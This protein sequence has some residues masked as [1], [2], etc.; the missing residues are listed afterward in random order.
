[1]FQAIFVVLRRA[2]IVLRTKDSSLLKIFPPRVS[3]LT[4]P[5]YIKN[6]ETAHN[7]KGND[8]E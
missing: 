1:M 6:E 8:N 3:F 5:F 7:R 2:F 4:S